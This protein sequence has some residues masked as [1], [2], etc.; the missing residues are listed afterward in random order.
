MTIP[1]P[2]SKVTAAVW[3]PC[4]EFILTGHENGSITKWDAKVIR[5]S[6]PN[7]HR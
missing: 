6:K 2:G 4:D 3:G 7:C 1:V 5:I